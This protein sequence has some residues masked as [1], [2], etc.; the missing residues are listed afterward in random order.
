MFSRI[1]YLVA[2]AIRKTFAEFDEVFHHFRRHV[3]P[4]LKH[5]PERWLV[6]HLDLNNKPE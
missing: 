6:V 3:R 1:P 2:A 5:Y 4:Q